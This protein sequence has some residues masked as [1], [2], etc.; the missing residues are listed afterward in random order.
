MPAAGASISAPIGADTSIP[1]CGRARC[2]IGCTRSA[3]NALVSH[4]LVGMIDGV[5]ARRSRCRDRVS[6]AW[7]SDRTRMLARRARASTSSR[8]ARASWPSRPSALRLSRSNHAPAGPPIPACWTLV[9]V[10][11]SPA[12][13]RISCSRSL[14]RCS[15]SRSP[16][17]RSRICWISFA[18]TRFSF[19]SARLRVMF[20]P[21]EIAATPST[22]NVSATTLPMPSS[23]FR[24]VWDTSTARDKP[25]P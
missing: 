24:K 21:R 20:T 15:V 22:R 3:M 12:S 25:E 14:K 23:V 2:R 19:S 1:S 18:R 11:V 13:S 8:A 4:P 7:F 6:Y 17:I 10:G 9:S 16:A 5:A